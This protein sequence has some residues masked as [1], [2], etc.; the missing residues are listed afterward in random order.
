M[1]A[2]G[3]RLKFRSRAMMRALSAYGDAI[4]ARLLTEEGFASLMNNEEYWISHRCTY[5]L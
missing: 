2:A 4:H 3:K 1:K 5:T